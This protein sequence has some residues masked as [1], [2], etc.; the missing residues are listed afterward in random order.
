MTMTSP[1][2]ETHSLR[3]FMP[4]NNERTNGNKEVMKIKKPIC[5]ALAIAHKCKGLLPIKTNMTI[6]RKQNE[7]K[8]YTQLSS[9]K[10][11][12]SRILS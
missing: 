3:A 6:K 5:N 1:I 12:L 10:P 11:L 9:Q 7:T 8:R 2:Y 4:K